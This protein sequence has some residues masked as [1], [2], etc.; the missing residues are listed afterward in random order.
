MSWLNDGNDTTGIAWPLD[1]S[2]GFVYAEC[3]WVMLS[4]SPLYTQASPS[5]L[6]CR[7]QA[8]RDRSRLAYWCNKWLGIAE[9]VTRYVPYASPLY[10][11]VCLRNGDR[12]STQPRLLG[13]RNQVQRKSDFSS[14]RRSP[15]L[16]CNNTGDSNPL[17]P[18]PERPWMGWDLRTHRESA[19]VS[20]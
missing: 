4:A 19:F 10:T 15:R 12:C 17:H 13:C 6:G 1:I 11:L 2:R 5:S 18:Y 16:R 9:R 14:W 20:V 8:L 3:N 7:N